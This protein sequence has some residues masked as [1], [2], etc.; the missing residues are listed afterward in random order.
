MSTNNQAV[1]NIEPTNTPAEV[2][3]PVVAVKPIDSYFTIEHQGMIA[4]KYRVKYS[5]A[6]Q[7]QHKAQWPEFTGNHFVL[8][9][10]AE[11]LT[12]A[13]RAVFSANRK[14]LFNNLTG[15][16]VN[17]TPTVAG[18]TLTELQVMFNKTTDMQLQELYKHVEEESQRID[19][20]KDYSKALKQSAK[21]GKDTDNARAKFFHASATLGIVPNT[22]W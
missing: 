11:T 16:M 13:K 19:L 22:I 15:A 8:Y 18:A 1:K 3:T 21:T 12:E 5:D 10:L 7:T 9:L 14:I 17:Y 4:A 2:N 20:L 6:D